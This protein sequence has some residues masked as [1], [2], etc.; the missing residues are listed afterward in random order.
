VA[1]YSV[2]VIQIGMAIIFPFVLMSGILW[3]LIAM[4][5]FLRIIALALPV[6][7][8]AEVARAIVLNQSLA[9]PNVA[10]AFVVPLAWTALNFVV[11]IVAIRMWGFKI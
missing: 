4:P 2:Q 7:I 9:V 3:P 5:D 11:C 6:T 10:M 1:G 8:P